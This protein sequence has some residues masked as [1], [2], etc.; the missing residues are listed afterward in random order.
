MAVDEEEQVPAPGFVEGGFGVPSGQQV[1]PGASVG[2]DSPQ[3]AA[4]EGG[5]QARLAA[6]GD[7]RRGAVGFAG[8]GNYSR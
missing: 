8:D 3:V 4:E 2:G 1:G 6:G 5:D 7:G